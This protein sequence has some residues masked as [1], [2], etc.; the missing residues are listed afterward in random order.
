MA[1]TECQLR[2]T[3]TSRLVNNATP[4]RSAFTLTAEFFDDATDVWSV[5]TPSTAQYRI[6]RIRVGDPS[7]YQAVLDWTTLSPAT[8]ISIPI[9]SDNNAIQNDW[10]RTEYRLVTVRAD[11]GLATQ[12]MG[13][14]NY[15]IENL[16]GTS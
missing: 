4:E 15:Q 1:L 11:S 10:N 8:S 9:T 3:I 5:S 14:F 6:D 2:V 16:A 13:T 12:Y 7:C